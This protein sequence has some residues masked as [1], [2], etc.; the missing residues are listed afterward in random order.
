MT[1]TVKRPGDGGHCAWLR[2]SGEPRGSDGS[3]SGADLARAAPHSFAERLI[4]RE[5][6]GAAGGHR[7]AEDRVARTIDVLR[8]DVVG[9]HVGVLEVEPLAR[10]GGDDGRDDVGASPL[11]F[12]APRGRSVPRRVTLSNGATVIHP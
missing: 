5:D 12:G 11:A 8:D 2:G 3:L 6:L 4:H 7:A 1:P 9:E 10:A